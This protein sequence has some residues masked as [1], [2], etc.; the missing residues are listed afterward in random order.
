MA[1]NKR[2]SSSEPLRPVGHQG[3]QNPTSTPAVSTIQTLE[4]WPYS[5]EVSDLTRENLYQ[6]FEGLAIGRHHLNWWTTFTSHYGTEV[7]PIYDH[8]VKA[9]SIS[10]DDLKSWKHGDEVSALPN[11][12]VSGAVIV[13]RLMKTLRALESDAERRRLTTIRRELLILELGYLLLLY[14]TKRNVIDI[15]V[16]DHK[17]RLDY[18]VENLPICEPKTELVKKTA[19]AAGGEHAPD[20]DLESLVIGFQEKLD[21]AT[22]PAIIGYDKVLDLLQDLIELPRRFSHLIKPGSTVGFQGILL[23]G[24]PGTGKTL[25]AQNLAAQQGLA[26]F[27][28][29]VER[30]ISKY[31]GDTEK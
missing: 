2:K 1:N 25:M 22:Q 10:V 12:Q 30:L 15:M 23:F 7:D 27:K 17:V 29:P 5:M 21:P 3:G 20:D 26:F 19:I 13:T 14:G 8:W 16:P 9:K 31:V 18:L 4:P 28:I 24:P 6:A 11:H